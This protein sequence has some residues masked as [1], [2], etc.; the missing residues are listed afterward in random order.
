MLKLCAVVAVVLAGCG[1]GSKVKTPQDLEKE[2][3]PKLFPRL[4]ALV[5]AGKVAKAN[6]GSL[7]EPGTGPADLVESADPKASNT[8]VVHA[9]DLDDLTTDATPQVRFMELAQDAL[10]I[11]KSWKGARVGLKSGDFGE[12]ED[13]LQRVIGAKYVVVVIPSAYKAP[14][15]G[16][17][18]TFTPGAA[19]ATA[20]LVEIE[21]AKHLGGV[22][23]TAT[24]KPEVAAVK[25][26][27]T[28][29][30]EQRQRTVTADLTFQ[31]SR[32]IA[33]G[34]RTRWKGAQIPM[35]WVSGTY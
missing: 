17:G 9:E 26:S 1:G 18:G 7:G 28:G 15:M 5:A 8:L 34:V 31:Y 25:V 10:R 27:G 6:D 21:G 30:L 29:A 19:E 14:D 4:D 12:F 24:N 20:V 2:Y 22:R 13:E 23:V 32:A 35:A 3:G 33:D 16:I 11:A